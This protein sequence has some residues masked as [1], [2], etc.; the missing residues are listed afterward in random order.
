MP[1]GKLLRAF[2]KVFNGIIAERQKMKNIDLSDREKALIIFAIKS[3]SEILERIPFLS[4]WKN[5]KPAR[6]ITS[7]HGLYIKLSD[8]FDTQ[9]VNEEAEEIL[10]AF[11]KND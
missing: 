2:E 11:T 10:Q 4:L 3:A 8:E 7:L 5:R 1:Y 9:G 6:I